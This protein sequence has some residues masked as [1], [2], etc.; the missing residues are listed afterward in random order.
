LTVTASPA[1]AAPSES[2][3]AEINAL[4]VASRTAMLQG[5]TA[6]VRPSPLQPP[7]Q[8]QRYDAA[9]GRLS[10]SG[11][12]AV[13][14]AGVGTYDRSGFVLDGR[15]RRGQVEQA[16][17]YL[18]LPAR[19][20]VLT[21]RQ[22]GV[23]ADRTFDAF[24][25]SDLL[26]PDRYID[27]DSTTVP[28]QPQRCAAHVLRDRGATVTSAVEGARTTYSLTYRLRDEGI[29]VR[30]SLVAEGGRFVAGTLR[31][32][33]ATRIDN[34]IT[35]TYGPQSVRVPRGALPQRKWIRATDAA[36]LAMDLRMLARSIPGRSVA[37]VRR[38]VRAA[39]PLANRGHVVKLRM[40][41]VAG[42]A[43][44]FGRNPFTGE[45]IAYE[46]RPG[47]Q[48]R[49]LGSAAAAV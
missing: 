39:L 10:D 13:T 14:V 7:L 38:A 49:R 8:V 24:L 45:V 17:R 15:L 40:R 23:I 35:W 19:P 47:Q 37:G 29:R 30:T 12:P 6:T 32:R 5:G 34:S 41:P 36:A 31:M 28:A 44:L 25:R 20:W 3:V 9:A 48:A 27:L 22:Y 46:V 33:G 4:C 26:A 21:R 42:G 18:G 43:V 1:F 16:A 2:L 11:W